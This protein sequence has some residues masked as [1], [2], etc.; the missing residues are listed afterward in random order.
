MEADR[1][2]GNREEQKAAVKRITE[3]FR[4]RGIVQGRTSLSGN[5]VEKLHLE[6]FR[7]RAAPETFHFRGGGP[8]FAD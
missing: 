8:L 3:L 5:L 7:R 2:S 6:N 1:K 4:E